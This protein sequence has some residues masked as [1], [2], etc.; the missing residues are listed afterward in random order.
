MTFDKLPGRWLASLSGLISVLVASSAQA[1]YEL[2][3]TQGVTP[4]SHEI[5]NLHMIVFWIC[6][7]IGIGVNPVPRR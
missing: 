3:M 7:V 6:V 5:Y 4:I 2:N 1:E